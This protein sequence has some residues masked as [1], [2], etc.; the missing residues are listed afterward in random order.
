MEIYQVSS[1]VVHISFRWFYIIIISLSI[2]WPFFRGLDLSRFQR[3]LGAEMDSGFRVSP[4]SVIPWQGCHE[5]LA[6]GW[7]L[8]LFF[9][10][11][12]FSLSLM[13]FGLGS[14]VCGEIS[15][16]F[17]FRIWIDSSYLVLFLFPFL[18][19]R[20][21]GKKPSA[22]VALPTSDLWPSETLLWSLSGV[23]D[24][25]ANIWYPVMQPPRACLSTN[26]LMWRW[27]SPTLVLGEISPRGEM[28]SREK[29][30]KGGERE[31]EGGSR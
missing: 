11:F 17:F 15:F 6:F 7:G 27:K 22:V 23:I 24:S 4:T 26:Y 21:Q 12:F 13:R 29:G 20:E 5:V 8:F 2:P 28:R 16:I 14:S 31:R 30:G 19:A 18:Y 25:L 10:R 1:V 9:F 3:S